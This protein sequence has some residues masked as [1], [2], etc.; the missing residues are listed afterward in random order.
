MHIDILV[1]D[2]VHKAL[3]FCGNVVGHGVSTRPQ[4]CALAADQS[5]LLEHGVLL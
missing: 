1:S 3:I 2:C 5:C 4:T